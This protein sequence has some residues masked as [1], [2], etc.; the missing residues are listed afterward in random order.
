MNTERRR[1]VVRY[2]G[3]VQG[4]GFRF[5]A[6][7]LA[8]RYG[9]DGYVRNEPDGTVSLVAEGT[10]RQI[11][12]FLQDIRRSAVGRYITAEHRSWEQPTGA[13]KGFEIRY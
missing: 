2:E 11:E 10:A 9:V 8:Q 1:V 3:M 6:V 5:T 12:D 13:E 4:V 7:R